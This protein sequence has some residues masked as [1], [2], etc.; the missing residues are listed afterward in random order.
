MWLILAFGGSIVPAATGIMLSVVRRIV[1]VEKFFDAIFDTLIYYFQSK[2][3][4]PNS[5]SKNPKVRH[6]AKNIASGF[7]QAIYNVLGFSL[8]TLVPGM[9]MRF[10]PD[11]DEKAQMRFGVYFKHGIFIGIDFR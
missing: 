4:T 1:I 6:D 3:F 9:A 7:G 10:S 2:L 5:I 11:Q 8:G